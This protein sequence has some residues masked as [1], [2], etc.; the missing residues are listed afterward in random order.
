VSGWGFLL[1]I[2]GVLG[3]GGLV[4]ASAIIALVQTVQRKRWG[5]FGVLLGEGILAIVL[6]D[7]ISFYASW[8]LLVIPLTLVVFGIVGPTTPTV[9]R[10]SGLTPT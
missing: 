6:A 4:V 3:G 9:K 1:V 10:S 5:W 8:A 7:V 2:F